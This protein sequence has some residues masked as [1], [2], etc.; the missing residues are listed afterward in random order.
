MSY[1]IESLLPAYGALYDW[2]Y[3]IKE[4]NT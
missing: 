4:K 2:F 1:I 3:D